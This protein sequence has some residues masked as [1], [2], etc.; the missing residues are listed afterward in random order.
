MSDISNIIIFL[1]KKK[2]KGI[3]NIASGKKIHL[4]DIALAIL[5]KYKVKN[6]EFIDNKNPSTLIGNNKKLMK[7]RKF[8]LENNIEKLIF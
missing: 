6:F 8:K 7:L 2:Y 3:L 5:K 1:Y 4:K